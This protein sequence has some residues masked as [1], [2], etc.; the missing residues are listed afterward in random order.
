MNDSGTT[1][2]DPVL[3]NVKFPV[4]YQGGEKREWGN[5]LN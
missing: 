3:G 5:I 4:S 2:I 1:H